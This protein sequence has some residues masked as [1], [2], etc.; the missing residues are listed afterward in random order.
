MD[1]FRTR[2]QL[3]SVWAYPQRK[4]EALGAAWLSWRSGTH[5]RQLGAKQVLA[6]V[7]VGSQEWAL[8][9]RM[10]KLSK[11]ELPASRPPTGTP[12]LWIKTG[13]RAKPPAQ[14]SEF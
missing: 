12:G 2:T 14:E 6:D 11:R 5:D 10:Q 13:A 9:P 4:L 8:F 1:H 7:P 3:P